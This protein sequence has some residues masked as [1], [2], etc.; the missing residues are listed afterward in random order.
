[1]QSVD[2]RRTATSYLAAGLMFAAMLT[3]PR[4]FYSLSAADAGMPPAVALDATEHDF[5]VVSAGTVLRKA[6][7]IRNTGGQR[8]LLNRETCCGEPAS[9]PIA[10]PPGGSVPLELSVSTAGQHGP[11]QHRI[12]F[13]TSA[14]SKPRVTF[15]LVATV[16]GDR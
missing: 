8:L 5:G 3:M 7:S 11:M 16:T 12:T 14:P 15:S 6:F 1:M 4:V 2:W 10:I 13:T 9:A